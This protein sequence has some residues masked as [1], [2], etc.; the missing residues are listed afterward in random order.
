MCKLLAYNM[1]VFRLRFKGDTVR[2]SP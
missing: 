2:E 1:L